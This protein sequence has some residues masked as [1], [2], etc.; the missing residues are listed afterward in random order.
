MVRLANVVCVVNWNT[1]LL[2]RMLHR[3]GRTCKKWQHFSTITTLPVALNKFNNNST[4]QYY[5]NIEKI[6]H[7]FELCNATLETI[8]KI[9]ACLEASK[10]PG[11]DGISSKFL[12]DGAEVLALPLCNL[13]NLSMK[14]SLSPDQCSIA[15]LN[16][17]FKKDSK[18]DPKNY[19]PISLLPVVSKIIEKTI[20]IQTNINLALLNL[21]ILFSEEWTKDFTLGWS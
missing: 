8:K 21:R 5:M 14:Q 6:R 18:S 4:N 2:T 13:V 1:W 20:Q 3:T 9:L 10:A 15:K 11:L 19:R 7:N 17:L 16:P 12:K